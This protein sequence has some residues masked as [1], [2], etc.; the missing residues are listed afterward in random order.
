M[1]SPKQLEHY[2]HLHIPLSKAMGVSVASVDIHNVTL[3][4]FLQP[5]INHREIVFGGSASV[6]VILAAWS[7]LHSRLQAENM[8]CRLVIQR[9]TM[10]Y[11]LP[12]CGNFTAT[13]SLKNET[14]WPRFLKMLK[15]KGKARITVVSLVQNAGQINGRLFGEFV[16]LVPENI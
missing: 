5:N 2:L 16:A 1:V 8:Q 11:D 3:N 12:I 14:E 7:L 4:A 6:L 9:N 10:E 15:R 13:S